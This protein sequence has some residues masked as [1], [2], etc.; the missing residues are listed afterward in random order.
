MPEDCGST[1]VSTS[2]TAMAAS[3]AL[4]PRLDD[5]V[6]RVHCQR[7]GRGHHEVATLPAWLVS[8]A[9]G[10]FGGG[11]GLGWGHIVEAILGGAAGEQAKGDQQAERF[12]GHDK[13]L[14]GFLFTCR[15]VSHLE[16]DEKIVFN[17]HMVTNLSGGTP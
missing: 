5:L 2:W 7:I 6:A 1:R 4:T 12:E 14:V 10:R 8:P 17:T 11:Q 13:L 9:A 3:T 16:P 15:N